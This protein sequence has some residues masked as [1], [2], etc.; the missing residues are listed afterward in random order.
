MTGA[1][2]CAACA[3]RGV[4]ANGGGAVADE[5][6][7]GDESEPAARGWRDGEWFDTLM[8]RKSPLLASSSLGVWPVWCVV[9]AASA[10]RSAQLSLPVDDGV[11]IDL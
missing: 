6:S 8:R 11:A 1:A 4:G 10:C 7:C 9:F 2:A 5:A 3:A